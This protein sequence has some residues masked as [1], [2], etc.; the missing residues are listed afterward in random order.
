MR[1]EKV[2]SEYVETDRWQHAFAF[3]PHKCCVT[4]EWIWLSMNYKITTRRTSID[5]TTDTVRWM[6]K[7]EGVNILLYSTV[8]V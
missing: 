1:Y 5:E 8:R 4:G 2:T 3:L 7:K 6:E